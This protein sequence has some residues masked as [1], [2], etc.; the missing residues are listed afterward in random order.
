MVEIT[1]PF[2]GDRRGNRPSAVV[3]AWPSRGPRQYAL[4]DVARPLG[5][6]HFAIRTIIE[7][8][9]LNAEHDGMPLPRTPRYVSGRKID[10]PC[11][12]HAHSR[13]D[14]GEFDAW[15]YGRHPGAPVAVVSAL[16]AEMAQR[17]ERMAT[18]R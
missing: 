12:I 11:A 8:L 6:S 5:L 2:D 17:A 18:G 15:L 10:G 16:R 7:K 3:I 9:R 13:W 4:A 1:P 14:A